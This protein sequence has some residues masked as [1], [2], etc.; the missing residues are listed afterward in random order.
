MKLKELANEILAEVVEEI[1]KPLVRIAV[2]AERIA[3]ALEEKS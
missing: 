2:A 3:T 1:G